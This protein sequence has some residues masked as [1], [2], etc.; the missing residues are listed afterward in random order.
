MFELGR[1]N[2]I[3]PAVEIAVKKRVCELPLTVGLMGE[4]LETHLVLGI[5][6]VRTFPQSRLL[7]P[8]NCRKF[9]F[10]RIFTRKKNCQRERLVE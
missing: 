4:L 3:K 2:G 10:I 1:A 7:T 8:G 6:H 9:V 5:K